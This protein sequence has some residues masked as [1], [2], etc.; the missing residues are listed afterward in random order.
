MAV[1]F[2]S[3]EWADG[4]NTALTR[5]TGFMNAIADTSLAVQFNVTGAPDGDVSYYLKTGDG[6]AELSLGEVESADV[7]ITN[8][9]DTAAAISK[10]EL[11]TQAAFM[12]GKLKVAGNLAL[13]MMHQGAIAQWGA[14]VADLDIDY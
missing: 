13:L 14:A 9:Y 8:D 7:T 12:T 4:S 6:Q 1:T 5:H 11:N 2:L 3:A 10:G